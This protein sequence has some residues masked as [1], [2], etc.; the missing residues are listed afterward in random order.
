MRLK[1]K[2]MKA[3]LN[4]V[5]TQIYE[6]CKKVAVHGDNGYEFII[7]DLD[8]KVNRRQLR[9]YLSQLVQKGY[10]EKFEGCYFDFGVIELID[11]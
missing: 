2:I 10:L 4:E 11:K 8:V 1:T 6:E 5:E 3:N 9:G 7:D